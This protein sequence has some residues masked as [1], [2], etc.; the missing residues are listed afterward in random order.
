MANKDNCVHFNKNLL[1][2][3]PTINIMIFAWKLIC[4][5][6]LLSSLNKFDEIQQ[7]RNSEIKSKNGKANKRKIKASVKKLCDLNY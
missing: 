3:Q 5:L 4:T 6:I 2:R 7:E 1:I